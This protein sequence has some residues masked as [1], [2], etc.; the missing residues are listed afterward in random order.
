L[1]PALAEPALDMRVEDQARF[2]IE[3]CHL[4]G[5]KVV[6][7]SV[8][9]TVSIDSDLVGQHPEWF[10][11]VD[12]DA[13]DRLGGFRAPTYTSTDIA[14][15]TAMVESGDL[16]GLPVPREEYQALFDHMPMRVERDE[17][18]WKGIG[19]RGKVLRVPGAFADWPPDDPQ[20]AWTDVTYYKLHDH[21]MFR[22]MAYNT[23]RMFERDLDQASYRQ[24]SL[25]N[26]IS[27]IIPHYIR[28]FD[29]DGAMIDM[30]HALPPDLRRMIIEQCRRL[31]GDFLVLEENFA[32]TAASRSAG[33]DAVMGYLPFDATNGQTL[34]RFV[35]RVASGDIPVRYFATPESHNTP[36]ASAR[37]PVHAGPSVWLF[38]S[39]LPH[40]L[41]FLHAGME[42][43]EVR[44]VNTGLGFTEE[45]ISATLET[46][47]ALFN[48][49]PLPWESGLSTLERFLDRMRKVRSLDVLHRFR[50]DDRVVS[51]ETGDPE[52]V[53]YVRRPRG[54]RR[55]L[56]VCV[57]LSDVSRSVRLARTALDGAVSTAAMRGVLLQEHD[58]TIDIRRADVMVIPTV[59]GSTSDGPMR[60]SE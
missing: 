2:F 6:L 5:M 36:R 35:E 41:P 58:L 51:V 9:R 53:A 22:Y 37:L 49:V 28:M 33:Y 14:T 48:D 27:G 25:W 16:R 39:L 47:L 21:P 60:A 8:L 43:G 10:Y 13:A 30:G 32:L 29:I 34:A 50:A 57:N 42:L 45:E 19:P 12:N 15:A 56:L 46:D 11:W 18:G 40:G 52:V 26:M 20:P 31:K 44:P 24:T 7:E 54:D 17:M 38:L 23:V 1:D 3:L 59:H 4:L 55:G